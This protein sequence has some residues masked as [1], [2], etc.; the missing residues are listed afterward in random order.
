MADVSVTVI[1]ECLV[2]LLPDEQWPETE[3]VGG[4]WNRQNNP[5][6]DLVGA[7][8]APVARKI[9]FLGSIKWL[10]NKPFDHHD[11]DSLVRDMLAVPGVGPETPLVAV[12]RSGVAE[13]LPL[14]GHWGPD[15]LLR[16]WQT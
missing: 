6:I 2:R 4:W 13:D 16:A 1:R 14:A 12:S 15:D 7:D 3:V 10:E 11:Y 5:E 8:R 9:H